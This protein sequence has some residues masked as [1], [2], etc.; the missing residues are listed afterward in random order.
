[1][2]FRE[3]LSYYPLDFFFFFLVGSIA[4]T[5]LAAALV[6]TELVVITTLPFT[7]STTPLVLGL[8][9]LVFVGGVALRLR[10]FLSTFISSGLPLTFK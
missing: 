8:S 2:L 10:F 4:V 3:S 6:V 5:F 9:I 7:L 1:V